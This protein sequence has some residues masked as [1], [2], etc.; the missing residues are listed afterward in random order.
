MAVAA[1]G[2]AV[3]A[4]SAWL[5][6]RASDRRDIN[7]RSAYLHLVSDALVSVG[8]VVS[9]G[10]ILLT[11][12]QVWDPV[13]SVLVSAVMLASA[14]PLLREAWRMIFDAVPSSLD[15]DSVRRALGAVG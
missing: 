5:L 1:V 15:M 9:G 8:V 11:G 3:N 14:L 13:A 4:S 12:W 6:L 2:I 10:L 7:T